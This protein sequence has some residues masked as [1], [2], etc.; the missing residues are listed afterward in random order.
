MNKGVLAA[1]LCLFTGMAAHAQANPQ[2]GSTPANTH[3]M[4][5][6]EPAPSD[7]PLVQDAKTYIQKHLAS[8][9]V[10]EIREAY[11]QVVAGLNVKLICAV[12]S[13]DGPSDW[14]FVAFRSLDGRWHL[15][16]ARRI[17]SPAPQN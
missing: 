6:Y 11:T 3:R 7:M 15:T 8:M 4:G 5:A 16:S 10:N 13:D 14:Q 12:T 9:S 17:A 2:P 1:L